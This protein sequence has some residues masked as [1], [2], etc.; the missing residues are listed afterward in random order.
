MKKVFI[1]TALVLIG[2]QQVWSQGLNVCELLDKLILEAKNDFSSIIKEQKEDKTY[3]T[4]LKIANSSHNMIY[5]YNGLTFYARFGS[6]PDYK[7]AV[8]GADSLMTA[9][10][11]CNP[12]YDFI[13]NGGT[14]KLKVKTDKGFKIWAARIDLFK[15]PGVTENPVTA[16]L[17]FDRNYEGMEY[18]TL[19]KP[20]NT[21]ALA[22]D[23]AL[24]ITASKNKFAD[25]IGEEIKQDDAFMGKIYESKKSITGYEKAILSKVSVSYYYEFYLAKNVGESDKEKKHAEIMKLIAEAL[26]AEYYLSYSNEKQ[27]VYFTAKGRENYLEDAT[28]KIKTEKNQSGKFDFKVSIKNQ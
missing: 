16:R 24:V 14:Y 20:A 12:N 23:L 21:S 6:F 10:K 2:S 1:M 3:Q 22:Q 17:V 28:L 19:S 4:N 5:K 9:V 7:T 27:E 18:F 13:K 11:K 8:S 25:I 26:G 15:V